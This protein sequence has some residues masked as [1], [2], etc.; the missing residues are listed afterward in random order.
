MRGAIH[1]DIRATAEE[2]IADARVLTD[3]EQQKL[4]P[5]VSGEELEKLSANAEQVAHD[6]SHK[7]SL[8]KKLVRVANAQDR[9]RRAAK[10]ADQ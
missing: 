10:G 7:A 4:D 3:I 1:D 5:A 6:L 2:V 9:L 8:E